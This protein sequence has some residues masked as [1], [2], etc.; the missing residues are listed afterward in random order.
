MSVRS[1]TGFGRGAAAGGGLRVEVE[2][3]SVN[4]R[5]LDVATDL[6][7]ALAT[8]EAAVQEQVARAITRGRVQVA[9]HVR[10]TR[11]AGAEA[12][13]IDRARAAACVRSLREAAASLKLKDDLSASLLLQLPG[14]VVPAAPEEDGKTLQPLLERALAQAL[15]AHGAMRLRE[16]RAL[17]RDVQAKLAR[18]HELADEIGALAP[19]AVAR[20]RANLRARIAALA[21]EQV[22]AERLEREVI[23]FAE[24]A[25]ISEELVRLRSHFAQADGLLRAEAPAGKALDFLAQEFLREVNT[26][27]S[28][29][30]D[31]AIA[32]RVVLFKTELDRFR[33]QV[34]NI[35]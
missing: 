31:A 9:V 34:Q 21:A 3:S 13:R 5:Q 26:I 15:R 2:A 19:E 17:G 18:M 35:E 20:Y 7:R 1:M 28:K 4:R 29:A 11:A 16:G 24:R 27:G 6:P 23:V 14:V 30:N 8:L 32:Q 22:P 25:D 33:E 10:R 12:V